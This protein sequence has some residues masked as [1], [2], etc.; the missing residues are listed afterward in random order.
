MQWTAAI[1]AGLEGPVKVAAMRWWTTKGDYETRL[2]E[3]EEE[4]LRTLVRKWGNLLLYIFDRGFATGPGCKCSKH[5]T[6]DL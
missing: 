6:C 5:S 4:M 1:I 2:R 3:Q